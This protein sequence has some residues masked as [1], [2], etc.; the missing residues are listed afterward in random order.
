MLSRDFVGGLSA[1]LVGSLY[2]ILSLNLRTSA[3]ADSI[4]PAGLPKTLGILMI[5]LGLMLCTQAVYHYF[6]SGK[7]EKSEW[8]GQ[9]RRILRAAGLLCLGIAY[10]VAVKILGYAVSIAILLALV[11]MYQGAPAN[12]RVAAIAVGG[13]AILWAVFVLLLGVAMPSGIF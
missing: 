3:L 8:Q 10:L 1:L 2:L 5:L 9:G 4:G 7:P 11:A 13:A 12:W 6:K